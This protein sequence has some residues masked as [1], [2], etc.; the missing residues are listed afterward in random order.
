MSGLHLEILNPNQ[1]KLFPRLAFLKKKQFYLAGGTALALHLGHRTSLDFDFYSQFRFDSGELSSEIESFF[2]NEAKTT[3]RER[4]TLFCQIL[5]V[6]LSFFW[7]KYRLLKKPIE[8]HQVLLASVEDIA[9]MK[10]VSIIQRP[11]KRDYVDI[12][13]LLKTFSLGKMCSLAKKKYPSFNEYLAL[14]ALTFFE[15]LKEEE[16]REVNVLDKNFSWEEAKKKI[17]EEVKPYQLGM[18][19]KT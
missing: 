18:I 13:F 15:D 17:L 7:Y 1:K 2:S 4:E 10:L 19:K 5:E 9:A 6:D 14:R 3:L 8:A 16:K 12:F 11:V